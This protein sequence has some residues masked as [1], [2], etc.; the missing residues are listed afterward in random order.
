MLSLSPVPFGLGLLTTLFLEALVAT[1]FYVVYI[2][3]ALG[4]PV[5]LYT[6]LWPNYLII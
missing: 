2:F 4:F 1:D 3:K 5:Y 6:S